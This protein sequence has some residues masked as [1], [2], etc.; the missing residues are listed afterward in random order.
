MKVQ[1]KTKNPTKN[2]QSM[3]GNYIILKDQTTK[4]NLI[5]TDIFGI[6][7]Y[8]FNLHSYFEEDG[9]KQNKY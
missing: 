4:Y 8:T 6:T 5:F 3:L 2:Q 7:V 9:F 1:R